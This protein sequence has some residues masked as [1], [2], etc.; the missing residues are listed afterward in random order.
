VDAGRRTAV[1]MMKNEEQMSEFG[2]DAEPAS[3]APFFHDLAS[4]LSDTSEVEE[5]RFLLTPS[6]VSYK[7]TL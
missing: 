4:P 7:Y 1:A 6:Y 5:E 3:M 2:P